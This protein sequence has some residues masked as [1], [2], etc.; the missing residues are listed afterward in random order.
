MIIQQYQQIENVL[1][2]WEEE[3]ISCSASNRHIDKIVTRVNQ[4]N[5][6]GCKNVTS[7]E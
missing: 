3:I 7:R 1:F 4:I 6:P 5:L 2:S